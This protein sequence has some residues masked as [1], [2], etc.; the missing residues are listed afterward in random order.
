[1]SIW[2]YHEKLKPVPEKDRITLGEGNTDLL[3]VVLNSQDF[4]QL[5]IKSTKSQKL[6]LKLETQNPTKS[7][8]DRSLAFQISHYASKGKK[9]LIISSSGNAAI[10]AA[11]YSIAANIKLAIFVSIKTDK[12]KMGKL[13]K[14]CN[15][16]NLISL[17][18]TDKPKSEAIKYA[19][20]GNYT[21]LRGSV[22]EYAL[23]G[24]KTIAYELYEQVPAADAIFIPCSSGTSTVG[25]AFGYENLDEQLP[26]LHICQTTRI[27]PMSSDY[28][29][30]YK[31]SETSLAGAIVDRVAKRKKQVQEFINKSNGFGWVLADEEIEIALKLLK[32]KTDLEDLTSNG[33]L[34]FAGLI[35]AIR[36][37]QYYENPVCIISGR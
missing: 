7:F 19:K 28:D 2:E 5:K 32:E 29:K 24:F 1:M 12:S 33:I 11:N 22:D 9:K 36:R 27:H 21:N 16:S 14:L 6:F 17:V 26:A 15:K 23:E 30:A 13:T 18:I 35:K 34:S 8:K 10:S 37:K 3:K 4:K 20:S 25:I 31:E